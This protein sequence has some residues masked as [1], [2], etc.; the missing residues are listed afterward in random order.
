LWIIADLFSREFPAIP[1]AMNLLKALEDET[2]PQPI[3]PS[4]NV[5]AFLERI[6]T[7]DP[8]APDISEDDTNSCWGH[9][10]FTA[11][12]IRCSTV[13]TSW[14]EVGT[15]TA[16]KLITAALKTCKVA[17]LICFERSIVT[18]NQHLISV[19]LIWK[20]LWNCYGP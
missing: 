6:E 13:L 1:H 5:A 18:S 7:A 9:Y 4:A 2:A 10:Q 3:E 15:T 16:R 12:N 19:T 20:T 8:N 14:D 17:R 11:T